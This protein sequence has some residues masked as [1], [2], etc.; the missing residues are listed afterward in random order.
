M[1]VLA[2][3]KTPAAEAQLL[4][5]L[6]RLSAGQVP[7]GWQLDLLA[8]AARRGTPELV[9][10]LAQ[11]AAA[12]PADDPLAEYRVCLEG[13]DSERG[14]RLAHERVDLSC[15]RCHRMDEYG[16]LVGP[17][18]SHIGSQKTREYLL[19]AIV[20]PNRSIAKGYESVLVTTDEGKVISGVVRS[21]DADTLRLIQADGAPVVIAKA[22]IDSRATALSPMPGDLAGKMTRFELRDLVAYLASLK[23]PAD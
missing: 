15:V 11:L 22:N 17:D 7:P 1:S 8:A 3:L 18:L 9:E 19:E 20:L 4:Q 10:K 14:R 12:R 16:G 6:E 5:W 2:E 21:E 23:K 13:G